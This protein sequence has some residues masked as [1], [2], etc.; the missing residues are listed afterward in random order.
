MLFAECDRMS[1]SLCV[2]VCSKYVNSILSMCL[3]RWM[4]VKNCVPFHRNQNMVLRFSTS[5][6]MSLSFSLFII[7]NLNI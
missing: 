2:P 6:F 5:I 1:V 7:F 3:Y 4:T